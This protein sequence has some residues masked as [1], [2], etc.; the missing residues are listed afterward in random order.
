LSI[1]DTE[2]WVLSPEDLVLAKLEWTRM[3]RSARQLADVRALLDGVTGIDIEY[4][5]PFSSDRIVK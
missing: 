1:E 3:S 5:I 4:L 2:V